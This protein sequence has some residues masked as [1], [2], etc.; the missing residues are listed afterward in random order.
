M[1]PSIRIS[2]PRSNKSLSLY[3]DPSLVTGSNITYKGVLLRLPG[4]SPFRR[5][6]RA[7]YLL[8]NRLIT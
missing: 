4:E 1:T 5:F 7:P 8:C 6:E 3:K 2:W